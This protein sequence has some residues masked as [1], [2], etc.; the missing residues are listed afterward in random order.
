MPLSLC[1]FCLGTIQ[2]TYLPL[3]GQF[4]SCQRGRGAQLGWGGPDPTSL[5][6]DNSL[7]LFGGL[8]YKLNI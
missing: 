7:L 1:V 5:P 4:F 3:G 8:F 6:L 2:I